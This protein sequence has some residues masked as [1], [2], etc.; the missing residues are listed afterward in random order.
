MKSNELLL[1]HD[2]MSYF[3]FLHAELCIICFPT[4]IADP[5]ANSATCVFSMLGLIYDMLIYA[6]VYHEIQDS[7][8][9]CSFGIITPFDLSADVSRYFR[10]YDILVTKC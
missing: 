5:L 10:S 9:H 2:G 4:S 3:T 7:W 8:C 1:F 6:G